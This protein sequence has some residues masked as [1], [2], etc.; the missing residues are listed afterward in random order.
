MRTFVMF[1]TGIGMLALSGLLCSE[2]NADWGW[3]A[4]LGFLC[5]SIGFFWKQ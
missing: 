4:L 3:F 1:V 2:R 5:L